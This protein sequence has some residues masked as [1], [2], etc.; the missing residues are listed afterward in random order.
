MKIPINAGN[1]IVA[2]RAEG[3]PFCPSFAH[4]PFR[5]RRIS[6]ENVDETNEPN[7]VSLSVYASAI[8]LYLIVSGACVDAHANDEN[9][10]EIDAIVAKS[11]HI[12]I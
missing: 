2:P 7:S 11:F 4:S 5:F 1:R 9:D 10:Y 8:T 6:N 3:S 12:D